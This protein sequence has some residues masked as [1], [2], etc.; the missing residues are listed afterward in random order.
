MHV[1]THYFLSS[2][3]FL[4]LIFPSISCYAAEKNITDPSKTY[5]WK[6][7]VITGGG[8]VDGIIF[9]PYEKDLRYCRT[10]MGGAYRWEEKEKRWIPLLD[11]LSYED[12]NLMGVESIAIDPSDPERVYLACGTYTNE[13]TPNG[14]ILRST[15]RGNTFDRIDMPFK[16]GGNETGRGSGE[17]LTVDPNNGSILFL[18]T[19]HDGLWQSKDH[20][21]TWSKVSGFPDIEEEPPRGLKNE[22]ERNFWNWALKGSGIIVVIFDPKSGLPGEGSKIVYAAVSLKERENIFRSTDGGETWEAISG[23]PM[24]YRPNDMILSMDGILYLSYGSDPGPWRMYDGGIWKYDTRNYEWTDITPDRPDTANGRAFGYASVTVDPQHPE[25]ILA[26]TF[27]HPEG[28]EIY[29]STDRGIKWKP[30]FHEGGGIF[31]RSLAPY[32]QHTG[33]HWLFDIEI[34]PFNPDHA[35]FTTGYGGHETFNLSNMDRGEPTVWQIMCNGIEETVPLELLSPPEGAQLITAIGDYGGFVHWN[36]DFSPPEGN[37][38]NPHFGN[39]DGITCAWQK[40]EMIVRVGVQ[41]HGRFGSNIAY[42]LD[43]GRSWEPAPNMPS[44]KSRHG[45]I[46]V[47]ADGSS[48]IWTPRGEKPYLTSDRGCS[49]SVIDTLPENT[50]VIADPVNPDFFYAM[51]LFHDKLFRSYDGGQTFIAGHLNLSPKYAP[52]KGNRGDSRGGQDRLYVTQGREE[53]LWI[54]AFD[55]LFHRKKSDTLFH[56][57]NSITEI[58]A[59]GFGKS[60]PGN[61]YPALYLVGVI[62]NVQGIFQSNDAGMSW[63]RINDDRH[64]WGLLLH[65]TGDPKKYGRVYIGTHGRGAI[66]GDPL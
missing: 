63:I 25:I 1:R 14:V 42:S 45:T 56:Q 29:R 15:D 41:S 47:A 26:C 2:L 52:V 7:V 64:Q 32:T 20:G 27:Y 58:H 53:D 38:T 19:R 17:R 35:I 54:A 3:I 62:N 55:G 11:W 40:P 39:T 5:S 34:D 33:I 60:A 43:N 9:H 24:Q 13:S 23:Q 37:F 66:Y 59:F 57:I 18:G 61:D 28:E 50:R 48:W 22:Q 21:Q 49:W 16:F 30:I 36:L 10:D 4:I 51:D 12:L 31:D 6:N 46:A 8:Y 65:I 44:E